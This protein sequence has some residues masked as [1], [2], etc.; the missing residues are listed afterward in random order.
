M[1]R[2]LNLGNV[3]Q[4]VDDAFD[5]RTLSQ[6]QTII[7]GHQPLFHV[8]L[9]LCDQPNACGV[10]QVFGKVFADKGYVSQKLAKHLL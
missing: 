2:M 4:L 8:A 5:N 10:E 3:L 1:A 9:E 7:E 6:H